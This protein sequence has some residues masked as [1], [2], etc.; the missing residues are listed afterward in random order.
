MPMDV[1]FR[2][3][4]MAGLFVTLLLLSVR[5]EARNGPKQQDAESQ[6]IHELEDRVAQLE[7]TV[8]ELKAMMEAGNPGRAS[9]PAAANAAGPQ[10][11]SP[12]PAGQA[13]G[14]AFAQQKPHFEMPPELVPEIGKIG[15]EVGVFLSGSSGPYKLNT[16]NFTGG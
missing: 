7:Q 1:L 6:R 12:Q 13:S 10:Q 9:V 5:L 15:A 4:R 16:G 11:Q 3:R 14:T 8:A 2:R